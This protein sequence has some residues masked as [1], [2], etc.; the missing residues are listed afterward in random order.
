[1]EEK[2]AKQSHDMEEKNVSQNCDMEDENKKQSPDMEGETLRKM[3]SSMEQDI[4]IPEALKPERIEK[5]L[6]NKKQKR[7]KPAYTFISAAACVCL[8]IGAVAVG[9]IGIF[10]RQST[11]S[12]KSSVSESSKTE[13]EKSAAVEEAEATIATAEDYDEIYQYLSE[14]EQFESS[15][16]EVVTFDAAG[17]NAGAQTESAVGNSGTAGSMAKNAAADYSDTNVRE[18]GVGEADI[19]KT[20]GKYLYILQN[21][22]KIKV[23]DV[24]EE[25][26]QETAT[27]SLGEDVQVSEIYVQDEKL[28]IFGTET[29][30]DDADNQ[31]LS[32][33]YYGAGYMQNTIVKTF[34]MSKPSKPKE[35]GSLSQ[36]GSYYSMRV[37]GDCV[38]LLSQFYANRSCGVDQITAY[39]PSVQGKTIASD[40]IYM[41]PYSLG[42][43]YMVVT[44]FNM[45]NPSEVLDSKGIFTQ[46]GT[47]YVSTDNIYMCET[48][49]ADDQDYNQTAIRKIAYKDGRLTAV[50]QAKVWGALNDSFSIDEY[51]GKLRLVTTVS[52]ITHWEAVP[53]TNGEND[54]ANTTDNTN[55]YGTGTSSKT[56][57]RTDSNALYILDEK[58]NQLS[59]I[60]N[61]A[62]DE[63]VYSARFMGD[64]GYF[65]TYKQMDPLFSV[66]LSDAKNPKILGALKITGFSDYLHSYG[67]GLLLGIGMDMDETGTTT[68]GVKLSMFDITDPSDVGEIQKEVLKNMYSTDVSYDYRAALVDQKKNLIGFTAYGNGAHYMVYSYDEEEGFIC[69]LD[70]EISNLSGGIRGVYV[71][72]TLYVIEGNAIEAYNLNGFEKID[73]IVL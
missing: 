14:Q 12:S 55:A 15:T 57:E 16:N 68:E 34:D 27:V 25:E 49:Y 20:D 65:V 58:L 11:T 71:G 21:N 44:S 48:S 24:Q 41:P 32:G 42:S 36:S 62:E 13:A 29:K 43:Q 63:V 28:F 5:L 22:N 47:C 46:E 35:I 59:K 31:L 4:E 1:M 9:G 17:S 37:S 40:R 8:V 3:K 51:E 18:E 56:E 53:Y 7:W 6:Q 61:L 33:T 45:T 2:N 66:D 69:R 39:I 60:E 72:D 67:D 26:M 38:Y 64:T 52:P 70:K 19:V 10:D 54:S 30:Y 50:G 23:I 73:D